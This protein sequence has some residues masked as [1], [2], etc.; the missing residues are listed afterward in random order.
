MHLYDIQKHKEIIIGVV[1]C[2]SCYIFLVCGC[3]VRQA[4]FFNQQQTKCPI[5]A[6]SGKIGI[7]I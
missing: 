3:D 2:D 5:V 7:L 1:V 6:S 4:E